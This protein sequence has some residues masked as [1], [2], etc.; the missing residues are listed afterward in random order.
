MAD[1]TLTLAQVIRKHIDAALLDLHTS[2]PAKVVSYE[3]TTGMADVQPML[4]RPLPDG[5]SVALPV[6]VQV[7]VAYPRAGAAIISLPIKKGDTVQLTFAER[8]IDNWKLV[9]AEDAPGN[10]R[11]YHLA[12]AWAVPGGYAKVA[13]HPHAHADLSL[14]HI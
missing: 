6:I 10:R 8:S 13:P 5:S 2:M 12:D 4:K 14:I 3:P 1:E 11:R 9:G 7:P